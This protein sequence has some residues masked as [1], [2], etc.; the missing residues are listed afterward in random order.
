M[1]WFVVS[2]CPR[3]NPALITCSVVVIL[4]FAALLLMSTRGK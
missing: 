3:N 4:G 1:I 2:G